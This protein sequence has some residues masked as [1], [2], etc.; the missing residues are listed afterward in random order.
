M[1]SSTTMKIMTVRGEIDASEVQRGGIL[2]HQRVLEREGT[3]PDVDIPIDAL[4]RLRSHPNERG[5]L[6]LSNDDRAYRELQRLATYNVNCVVDIHARKHQRDVVRLRR[7][8]EQTNLHILASTSLEPTSDGGESSSSVD[9]LAHE[10]VLDLHYGMDGTD[11]QASIIYHSVNLDQ[12][13]WTHI[14]AVGQAQQATNAPIY[15]SIEPI[16]DVDQVEPFLASLSSSWNMQRVLLCHCDVWSAHTSKLKRWIDLTHVVLGFDMLGLYAVSN[17]LP[18]QSSTSQDGHPAA[19]LPPHDY[20]IASF[21]ADLAVRHQANVALSSTVYQTIQYAQYG[22]GG[23]T[24]VLDTFPLADKKSS[25][26]YDVPLALIQGY[27]APEAAPVPK[28]FIVCSICAKAFE[29]IVGEY[30]TKFDFVYCGTKCLKK[31]RLRGFEPL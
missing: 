23:M 30:F 7:L 6:V 21:V 20:A 28:H 5:N 17:H 15:L 9:A 4:M 11:I 22:G 1:A 19:L 26:L 31:H 24:H 16:P 12:I 8:A 14:Q 25:M 2:L 29:P 18:L 3:I 10:L 27:K 13:N